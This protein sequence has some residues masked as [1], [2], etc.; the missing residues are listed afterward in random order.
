MM[1][2]RLGLHQQKLE[3]VRLR[4]QQAGSTRACEAAWQGAGAGAA[5]TRPGGSANQLQLPSHPLDQLQHQHLSG[6]T[7]AAPHQTRP[8]AWPQVVS[9]LTEYARDINP[10]MAR[11][12]V[13]AISRIAL[14]ISDVNGIIE[15]LLT[16]LETGSEH[17]TA[18]ALIQLKDLLRRWVWGRA[19]LG[20]SHVL[21]SL[22]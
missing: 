10:A 4:L 3:L 22:R 16:F 15:R 18:E 13:K 17:I 19:A 20:V 21:C 11:E 1:R 9:E 6:N 7:A 2:L 5:G 8:P 14:A 12:A